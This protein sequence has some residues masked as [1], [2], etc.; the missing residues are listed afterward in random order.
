MGVVCSN[1]L[2]RARAL[3]RRVPFSGVPGLNFSAHSPPHFTKAFLTSS[4]PLVCVATMAGLAQNYA[5]YQDSAPELVVA[6]TPAT[7]RQAKTRG[8]PE[9]PPAGAD[10]P[11]SGGV[12]GKKRILGLAPW[13]AFAFV[14][15]FALLLVGVIVGSVLGTTHKK[16]S[17]M[18]PIS[19]N[20]LWM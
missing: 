15:I 20:A 3:F 16:P 17:S 6:K 2:L 13:T 10:V 8:G 1:R 12:K 4:Y 14:L 18:F 11:A 5:E 9:S 19:F 7:A